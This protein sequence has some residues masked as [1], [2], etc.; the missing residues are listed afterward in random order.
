MTLASGSLN[1]KVST[2]FVNLSQKC[3]MSHLDMALAPVSGNLFGCLSLTLFR[4]GARE[5]GTTPSILLLK[6]SHL[7]SASGDTSASYINCYIPPSTC[8]VAKHSAQLLFCL[9][10]LLYAFI[11]FNN[12]F[13]HIFEKKNGI[14]DDFNF[15]LKLY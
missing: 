13:R 15:S 7:A 11:R 8:L 2:F 3:R 4:N 12:L 6:L 9:F 1:H 5:M 10:Q 14:G